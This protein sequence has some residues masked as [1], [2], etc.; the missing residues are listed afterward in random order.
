VIVPSPK[1][2]VLIKLR[3]PH[4]EF[5]K[6]AARD[7][8]KAPQHFDLAMLQ[9]AFI[10]EEHPS[11]VKWL[12]YCLGKRGDKAS[13]QVV[14]AKLASVAPEIK[15]WL[16]VSIH[17]IRAD[18][19]PPLKLLASADRLIKLQG[20]T[21]AWT[22]KN[23]SLPS[24]ALCELLNDSDPQIRRWTI[25]TGVRQRWFLNPKV[26]V[27]FL[28]DPEFRVR[29]WA[30]HSLRVFKTDFTRASLLAHV[31]DNHPRVREW[32]AK[33]LA[34]IGGA[35][36]D[37]VLIALLQE[38][39]DS[40]V[41]QGVLTSLHPYL[42]QRVAREALLHI[43]ASESDPILLTAAVEASSKEN[44][45]L[46]TPECQEA[47]TGNPAALKSEVVTAA[48]L[49]ALPANM[50]PHQRKALSL[51]NKSPQF[52]FLL[53]LSHSSK[54]APTRRQPFIIGIVIALDDE[55]EEFMRVLGN[56]K[57]QARSEPGTGLPS[58]SFDAAPWLQVF[59]S[60]FVCTVIGDMGPDLAQGY[61][62]WLMQTYRP[63]LLV[64]IGIA[65]SLDSGCKLGS[66]VLARQV[67]NYFARAKAV[68]HGKNSFKF[69]GSGEPFKPFKPAVLFIH[70]WRRSGSFQDWKKA[71][72]ADGLRTMKKLQSSISPLSAQ[73]RFLLALEREIAKP[74][75]HC[76][77]IACGPPVAASESFKHW[78]K[79][80]NRKYLSLDTESSGVLTAASFVPGSTAILSIRGISDA[81]DE[82][83]SRLEAVSKDAIRGLAMRN[84]T[85][86]LLASLNQL[87]QNVHLTQE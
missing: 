87:I 8:F 42:T 78:V 48:I 9:A 70:S 50:P 53:G 58:V 7:I 54:T 17:Q 30:A 28:N 15:E 13:I 18:K 29:E 3:H 36:I 22:S 71:C 4:P 14:E 75:L 51:L 76:G 11:V 47:I 43:L 2:V 33:A 1:E 63:G 77:P 55:F 60:K 62:Q 61:S 69:L 64:N 24:S 65:A 83:K 72:S 31:R 16:Y 5:R 23:V 12:G 49:S 57:C 38:D 86:L 84:A 46:W 41:R 21:K 66:V 80:R 37:E 44:T 85:R 52:E 74:D 32:V 59:P 6:A 45:L 26:V 34:I 73:T 79:S 19:E 81:G 39:D 68:P 67:D 27:P 82:Q 10:A 25:L 35:G 40:L 20:L 56:P